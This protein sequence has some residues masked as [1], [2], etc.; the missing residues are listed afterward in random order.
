VRAA[1]VVLSTCIFAFLAGP[2]TA[3]GANVD[4]LLA[5]AQR[6]ADTVEIK[7]L[8]CEY[9]YY[10]D[11]SDWDAVLE[12]FTDDIVAEYANSGVFRGKDHVRALLYAI[13]YGKSGLRVGQL[14]DH[15][16]LQPV[17]DIAP[18]GQS[19][20]GR[21]KAL[22]LLGQYGEYARWQTG[23]YENEYR[24]EGGR[25]KISRI[26]WFETFTV[27]YEGGWTVA[28]TRSNV[29]DRKIPPPDSPPT[30]TAD[31]WPAV[32]LPPYHYSNPATTRPAPPKLGAPATGSPGERLAEARRL[33]GLVRDEHQIEVL[34]RT[35]GF[36]VD[37]NL[38]TQVA[39]LFTD[40]GTLEIGGR[41]VF[42]GKARV[43][44]YLQ[45]LGRPE[46]GKLYDHTQMEPVVTVAPDGVT[47]KGRWRALIF[48]ADVDKRMDFLGDAIYENEYRKESGVW[49][50]AKLHAYFVLYTDFQRGWGVTFWALTTPEVDLP[51]DRKPSARYEIYPGDTFVPYH[52]KPGN[53]WPEPALP[54]LQPVPNAQL[55]SEAAVL[56]KELTRLEDTD[57]I[58]NL[59]NA[60]GFYRDKWQWDDAAK[61][62]AANGKREVA[63][64]G[65]YVG[66]QHV[67]RSF[68]IDGPAGLRQGEVA[69]H[70][71][72]Q[73]VIH[74]SDDGKTAHARLR[75]LTL[76]GAF[77]K[78]AEVGGE[79]AEN[80]FV[81]EGG[82]WKIESEHQYT[83]FWADYTK[84]WSRGYM[85]IAGPSSQV[86]PDKAPTE[87]YAAFPDYYVPP[88]HYGNPVTG[89]PLAP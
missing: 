65:V 33:A 56:D 80:T 34:Q 68:D 24:K 86:P 79:V 31:P 43:L 85:S 38:W 50:I 16:Q 29:A 45:Y 19:A 39:D 54:G 73:H 14:R 32:T 78:R 48:G 75:E 26:H 67:R 55:N 10:L 18:D 27:P 46:R 20:R 66:R 59:Q 9:G 6:L 72:Y 8:Q 11:R 74:V 36:L 76:T 30:F 82:I 5:R 2:R 12:L 28:M 88:F 25:W 69:E 41:G 21:W 52:Y 35:Y 63:Q 44:Q 62:F 61:L 15:I 42:V 7:R 49:K 84:G 53:S 4:K 58:E 40:D 51:P 81:K 71:L 37:K 23:P 17:I 47:A 60:Y 1:L 70:F 89:Q 87:V 83:T 77:G 13:G 3:E 57:A 22:V 64:R